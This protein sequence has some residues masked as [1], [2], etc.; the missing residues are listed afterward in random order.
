M[1][2]TITREE[3]DCIKREFVLRNTLLPPVK[4]AEILGCSVRKVF[5]LI[6]R[7]DL[8]EANDTPGKAGTRVVALSVEIYK[9]RSVRRAA[10]ARGIS[11]LQNNG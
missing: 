5:Y 10:E 7:G 6:E 4:V 2:E 1:T 3:I 8:E 9:Q 11:P